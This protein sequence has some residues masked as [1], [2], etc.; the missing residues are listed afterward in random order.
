MI[1]ATHPSLAG[2][3]PGHPITPGVVTLDHVVRGLT[4]QLH[5]VT[6]CGLPRVKFLRPLLPEVEVTVTYELKSGTLYQ[7]SCECNATVIL[8]G[9]IQLVIGDS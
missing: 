4:D 9:Q 6:L 8:S 7:F 5:G 3:F 1:S 2:H